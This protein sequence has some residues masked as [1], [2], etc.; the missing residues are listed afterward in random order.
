MDAKLLTKLGLLMMTPE[1]REERMSSIMQGSRIDCPALA[2]LIDE[3]RDSFY[4]MTDQETEN[5]D[6]QQKI[7]IRW[8]LSQIKGEDVIRNMN[9]NELAQWVIDLVE[10]KGT[11]GNADFATIAK[12]MMKME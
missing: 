8:M 10:T 9:P 11:L 5:V 4:A 12:T 3:C 7:Q 2:A 6:D 1:V